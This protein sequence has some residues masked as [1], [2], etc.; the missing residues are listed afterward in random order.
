[1]IQGQR[2]LGLIPARGGSKGLPGKNVLPLGGRPLIAWSIEAA[3]ASRYVDSVVVSSDDEAIIAVAENHGCDISLIR[4]PEL[5]TDEAEALDVVLHA[6]E[7]V[8]GYDILVL[9]QPTSPLRTGSDIDHALEKMIGREADSCVSVVEP[10]KSPFWSY[11]VDDNECLRPLMDPAFASRRRQ[12]L[13]AAYVLNGALYIVRTAWLKRHE[14][15][16]DGHTL[17]YRMP[18]E[19]S[20]DID[21]AFDLKIAELYLKAGA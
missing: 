9:L 7:Q 5:A 6:L 19:R 3:R 17:A 10:E 2:V 16:I 4:P 21:T 13:P 15:L 12:D 14:C 20:V 18:K 1:M 11:S 8:P